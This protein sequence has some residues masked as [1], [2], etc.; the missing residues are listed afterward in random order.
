MSRSSSLSTITGIL[1]LGW[2]SVLDAA[3]ANLRPDEGYLALVW[4]VRDRIKSVRVNR[5]G[6]LDEESLGIE[7]EVGKSTSFSVLD[8]GEWCLRSYYVGLTKWEQTQRDGICFHVTAGRVNYGGHVQPRN[9][10]SNADAT[11]AG[12]TVYSTNLT[13]ALHNPSD[14]LSMMESSPAPEWRAFPAPAEALVEDTEF[15]VGTLTR[16]GAALRDNEVYTVAANFLEA[17]ARLGGG[18]AA[19]LRGQMDR[20][21]EGRKAN[22]KSAV[23]WYRKS[24]ALGYPRGQAMFC[25]ALDLGQ[26]VDEDPVS[27]VPHCQSAVAAGDALGQWHMSR[28]IHRGRGGLPSDPAESARLLALASAQADIPQL[29]RNHFYFKD[30]KGNYPDG[31]E[32]MRIARLMMDERD[33]AGAFAAAFYVSRGVGAPQDWREA[34]RLFLLAAEWGDE[35]GAARRLAQ[36]FRRGENG[37]PKDGRKALHYLERYEAANPER[38]RNEL[39]WFLATA[40]DAALRDGKRA[41]RIMRKVVKD[42]P[43]DAPAE[44]D[45]L[46]AAFAAAGEFTRAAEAQARAIALLQRRGADDAQIADYTSRLELY[47]RGEVYVRVEK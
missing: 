10:R 7:V 18:E 13:L 40:E 34:E 42:G 12:G 26:G 8:A 32:A 33:P 11:Y 19:F 37:F 9:F 5:K 15:N 41:I 2:L 35:E 36:Y 38:A 24:A 45:T 29:A 4:D 21:G 6:K 44:V 28:M 14:F 20:Y 31:E 46:A 30:G 27:A 1:L 16:N 3:P 22:V 17:A 25:L 43:D 47:R 39:A 23:E